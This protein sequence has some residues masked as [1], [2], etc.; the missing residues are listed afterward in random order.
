MDGEVRRRR[1]AQ[2]RD[3]SVQDGLTR[4]PR[5]RGCVDVSFASTPGR[6][7]R[8]R[9][10]FTRTV[11]FYPIVRGFATAY[12]YHNG[13]KPAWL[14]ATAGTA[15]RCSQWD[16]CVVLLR[17]SCFPATSRSSRTGLSRRTAC[18]SHVVARAAW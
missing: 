8:P 6:R 12:S 14:S 15:V 3:P 18:L 11:G 13:T 10:G 5:D 1:H 9:R 16:G 4:R 2:R 17:L 7:N